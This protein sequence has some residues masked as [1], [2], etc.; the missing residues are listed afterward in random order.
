[1]PPRL[2]DTRGQAA[3]EFVTLLPLV[4]VLLAGA[5]QAVLGA[6]AWWSA[7]A[8]ARAAARAGAIGLDALPAAQRALP[9]SL[10]GRAE[11]EQ[12]AGSVAVRLGVPAVLPGLDLG[13]VTARATFASQR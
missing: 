4:L 11:V 5:W 1:M 2:R 3:V 10:D 7:H 6:Q 8:A 9:A 13:T 12:D